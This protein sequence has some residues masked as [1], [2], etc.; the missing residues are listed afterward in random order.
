MSALSAGG[1]VVI[2]LARRVS[3]R[4]YFRNG[5][6]IRRQ[7]LPAR[8]VL[9]RGRDVARYAESK[10][11]SF[12]RRGSRANHAIFAHPEHWYRVSIPMARTDIPKGTL[13]VLL[14]QI[15]GTWKGPHR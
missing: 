14:K 15:D 4:S 3:R 6:I 13:D 10:G 7:R 5:P 11:W 1:R 8:I 2:A 12:L 9:M